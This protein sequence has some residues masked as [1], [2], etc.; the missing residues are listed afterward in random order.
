MST[1]ISASKTVSDYLS[2]TNLGDIG[3]TGKNVVDMTSI[4]QSE[5]TARVGIQNK[6]LQDMS[7]NLGDNFQM[8]LS[9]SSQIAAGNNR[10]SAGQLG[11]ID[12][13]SQISQPNPTSP[14]GGSNKAVFIG[15][16]VLVTLMIVRKK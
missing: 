4:M 15:A 7:Y 6:T 12:T 11:V 5:E 1:G 2:T 10:V 16:A 9:G 3:V 14:F 13:M 8:L